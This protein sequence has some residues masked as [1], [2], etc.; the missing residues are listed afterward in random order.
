MGFWDTKR[1]S[2][3]NFVFGLLV[4]LADFFFLDSIS[5]RSKWQPSCLSLLPTKFEML[6]FKKKNLIS[7]LNKI[8]LH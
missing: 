3:H 7:Q 1:Q 5:S 4:D 2:F 8:Y 6:R